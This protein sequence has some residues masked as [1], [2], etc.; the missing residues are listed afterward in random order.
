MRRCH[1]A[2]EQRAIPKSI[3]N[4]KLEGIL[5]EG[6]F[7]SVG[8]YTHKQLRTKVAFK[9]SRFPDD[10]NYFVKEAGIMSGLDHPNILKPMDCS[11][12][13]DPIWFSMPHIEHSEG[14]HNISEYMKERKVPFAIDDAVHITKQILEALIYAHQQGTIHRDI[15]PN[16]ILIDAE[17][18]AYLADFNLAKDISIEDS[19]QLSRSSTGGG[20]SRYAS[21]EQEEPRNGP[22]DQRTDVYSMGVVLSTM[23]MGRF[24]PQINPADERQDVTKDL[25]E[26]VM[27][28]LNPRHAKRCPSAKEFYDRLCKIALPQQYS[29]K[30]QRLIAKY[31]GKIDSLLRRS[32]DTVLPVK[33]ITTIGNHLQ[34]LY[35]GLATNGEETPIPKVEETVKIRFN[36]DCQII[37]AFLKDKKRPGSSLPQAEKRHII[38]QLESFM[39]SY[40]AWKKIV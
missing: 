27:Y 23:L 28:T 24:H 26:L 8:L 31:Q 11:L 33:T 19:L 16:N 29:K 21:P 4:Y 13:E 37:N 7:S 17:L 32:S 39:D 35:S 22:I 1:M 3:G 15:K 18:T 20:S 10:D 38:K 40:K 12:E 25:G 14:I 9:F 6:S 34:T 5:G 2:D 36:A 30:S